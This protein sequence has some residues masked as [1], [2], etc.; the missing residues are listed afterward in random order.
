MWRPSFRQAGATDGTR[1]VPLIRAGKLG[2]AEDDCRRPTRSRQGGRQQWQISNC[3]FGFGLGHAWGPSSVG[4]RHL[5]L[6]I[7]PPGPGTIAP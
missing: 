4:L 5:P 3:D 6:A 1:R 2:R 7:R